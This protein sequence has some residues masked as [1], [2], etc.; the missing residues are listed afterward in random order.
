M[1]PNHFGSQL[2]T[3]IFMVYTIKHWVCTLCLN[4]YFCSKI[5]LVNYLNFWPQSYYRIFKTSHSMKSLNFHAKILDFAPKTAFLILK[6]YSVL[7]YLSAK[8][9]IFR[10]FFPPKIVNF[11]TKIQIDFEVGVFVKLSN[12]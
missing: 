9:Q 2:K 7:T 8:I 4:T 10:T 11:G 5:L 1:K 3:G 6:N 12:F